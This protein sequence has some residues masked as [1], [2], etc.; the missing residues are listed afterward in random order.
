MDTN[1]SR[2]SKWM[3][4]FAQQALRFKWISLIFLIL[5][6]FFFMNQAKGLKFDGAFESWF[7]KG[8]PV[9]ARLDKFKTN[10]GNTHFVYILMETQDFFQ[11]RIL[12]TT[13][14]LA[15]ELEHGVPFLRDVTW[16]GN[17]EYM[18]QTPNGIRILE[19]LDTIPEDQT[20]LSIL[21]EKALADPDFVN[22]YISRDGKTGAILLEMSAYPED[23]TAPA[24]EAAQAVFKILAQP[25]YAGLNTHVVG[26]PVFEFSYNKIAER[27]TPMFLM[28]CILVQIVLLA[29]M[30]R[31][32]KGVIVPLL[33][34]VIGIIWTFGI[35]GILGYNLTLMVMG[36]PVL[37]L[38]VGI[39]DAMHL[40]SAF[41]DHIHRGETKSQ[42]IVNSMKKLALPCLFTTLT[43]AAG[44]F[45][46][47]TAPIAPFR[48]M[49][50]CMA[51]GVVSVLIITFLLFP[52]FYSFGRHPVE[53]RPR[54]RR[55]IFD[56]FLEG[57]HHTVISHPGKILLIFLILSCV[58]FA[59][60][61]FLKIESNTSKLLT[62]KAPVRR[63]IDH[64]DSQ[65][66]G[67]MSLEIVLDTKKADGVKD[68]A[69]MDKL[70]DLEAY[71]AQHPLTEDTFSVLN[72]LKKMRQ[73]L[74]NN[75]PTFYALPESKAALADYLMTYEIAGGNH[76]DK[77]VSFD[78]RLL[79]LN[80][81]TRSMDTAQARQILSDISTKA[82]E[83]FNDAAIVEPTG[84]IELS[85]A[86]TDNMAICQK[87]GFLAA[88]CAITL[89][90]SLVLR[91]FKLGL[92]SMIPNIFPAV[93]VLGLMGLTGMFLDPIIMS[94]SAT[95]IGVGVDD[96]IHFFIQFRREF[97]RL[98]SYEKA[99]KR[100]LTEAG[101]PILFTTITLVLGFSCFIF[102][103]MNGWI[104]FGVLA[105]FAFTLAF[106]ADVFVAPAF[107][108]RFK[109]LG[110]ETAPAA[111]FAQT[112]V[113]EKNY[114]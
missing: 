55:D 76:L 46:F 111:S 98:G 25:A 101:R 97:D 36:L 13:D 50:V 78:G 26:D 75:D 73:A 59:G 54:P 112:P 65:M 81:R 79:R 61:P 82:R 11:S 30:S 114:A 58:F 52:F 84:G 2:F 14:R 109:P 53:K 83:I 8:D 106:L 7:V 110:E 107:F 43:T 32:I 40:V 34:V 16:V 80:I 5:M 42:A 33:V 27:E 20:Q 100:T 77:V 56:R 108:I 28:I 44:F 49:A 74:H 62:E 66:G 103:I 87:V 92:L 47:A 37:L 93:S 35:T 48:E 57:V 60:I 67:S 29:F 22:Q 9:M 71:V 3:E 102:S 94:I 70:D 39:A 12:K 85:A 18:E 51:M 113:E 19:L 1:T 17:A 6:T 96:T 90:I 99:L 24:S 89:I 15:R 64:V 104:R 45:S 68:K 95:I 63:A 23:R 69:F 10:F 38:C 4:T 41:N 21:K 72:L 91:S 86:F 31:S 88:F 105:G